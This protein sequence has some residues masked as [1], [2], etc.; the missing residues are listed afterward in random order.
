M[1]KK[2]AIFQPLGL[3]TILTL[4][5]GVVIGLLVG[6]FEYFGE[7]I[8]GGGTIYEY[9][10]VSTDGT[11]FIQQ[12]NVKPGSYTSYKYFSLERKEI[13]LKKDWEGL[14]NATLVGPGTLDK[15]G[16]PPGI[17][18]RI[19][20]FRGREQP[21]NPDETDN[22][23]FIH[24]GA[25]DGKG[26]FAG[27]NGRFKNCIGYIGLKG[28]SPDLP[29]PEEWFPME[30][31]KMQ[32]TSIAMNAGFFRRTSTVPSR[33]WH[34]EEFE[35][36]DWK[37][38]FISGNRL[39]DVDL[40]NGQVQTLATSP[41]M[42]SVAELLSYA[43]SPNADATSGR[44]F[45][46]HIVLRTS[47]RILILDAKGKQLYSYIIPKAAQMSD[48]YFSELGDEKAL[49]HYSPN[50]LSYFSRNRTLLWID[51]DGKILRRKD[52]ALE[53]TY[54]LEITSYDA[55]K[56]ALGVPASVAMIG[57][58][59]VAAPMSYLGEETAPNYTEALKRSVSETWL[60][61]VAVCIL[62][63][64]LA[65][66]CYRR[67]RRM[68]QPW[69]WIWAGFVFLFGVPGFL[70]YLFHRRWPVLETCHVC[71]HAVPHDRENC[72]A[73]GSEFPRLAPKGIEV[74]A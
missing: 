68:A 71:G 55:W 23:Y 69:A 21:N 53:S 34:S 10:S 18:N 16:S 52:V 38:V 29:P 43:A 51:R 40:T 5:F 28:S 46:Q 22:W 72:S 1:S 13:S 17:E 48:F 4:G 54:S 25:M 32:Q 41:D 20:A 42:I 27:Y 66:F 8:R 44:Q 33:G 63:A 58:A 67:Q 59:A 61:L 36:P 6:W 9:I 11:V 57:Y 39:L 31:R 12:I 64:V 56:F 62:S 73:C 7:G 37:V 47:D 50:K 60:P 15:I 45:H 3:A 30:G 19:A 35:I 26:Y 49:L 65:W 70:G 74:F 2:R 14:P 24:N